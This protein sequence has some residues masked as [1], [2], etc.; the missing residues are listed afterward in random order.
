MLN[1]EHGKSYLTSGPVKSE[2]LIWYLGSP[3]FLA[4]L[5]SKKKSRY[6]LSSVVV[7]G[8]NFDVF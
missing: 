5:L 4:R 3:E 7:D 6:C 8:K 2:K 1:V